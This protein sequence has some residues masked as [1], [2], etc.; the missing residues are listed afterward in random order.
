[1]E[2]NKKGLFELLNTK[3]ALLFGIIAGF[4]VL[5]TI[6]FFI[7][8]VYV[9]SGNTSSNGTT[10]GTVTVNGKVV[11]PK[12]FSACLDTGKTAA[13]VSA[14]QSLGESLG[15]QGTPATFIN[16]YLLSGALP[17]EAVKGTVEAVLAGRD[18]AKEKTWDTEHYGALTKYNVPEIKDAIWRGNANAKVT[19]VEWSDFE[20]PYCQRFVPTIAQLLTEYKDQVRFS[21][22]TFPLSF[23][24]N[25][26]KAAEAY[27]CAKEQG[28]GWEMH[29][30]LYELGAQQKLGVDSI[31]AAAVELGLK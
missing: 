11:G 6:G 10:V 30:K 16:G 28:K 24:A 31:K 5:C 29:D 22:Q 13:M 4:L 20:C 14:E 19:V 17:Y 18:P 15:V 3:Q 1:M 25:A 9:L 27:E 12:E 26:Q 2:E 23:H 8:L 21:Y 7:L